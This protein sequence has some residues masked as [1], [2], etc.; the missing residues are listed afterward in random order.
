MRF[1]FRVRFT[2]TLII[3]HFFCAALLA[4]V[5]GIIIPLSFTRRDQYFVGM[6]LTEDQSIALQ[7]MLSGANVF[8][9]GGA[10]AGK[11]Y[12]V[13]KF[14]MHV[15]SKEFPVLASTGAAAVLVGG[16]TFHSF[17]GLGIMDG[18]PG[19]TLDRACKDK[20]LLRRLRKVEG[21]IIDEVSMIPAEALW[22]AES[23]A[24]FARD[25]DHP[26]GGLRVIAVGD[27]AQL[28]PVHKGPEERPWAFLSPV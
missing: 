11:S 10:G 13:K 28:P 15:S 5:T 1:K 25:N 17:F 9:T 3:P 24:R 14:M 20:R 23:V 19:P 6:H 7:S 8:L 27:F 18:G 22:V 2:K 12:V 16:R 4:F 21:I 26:W